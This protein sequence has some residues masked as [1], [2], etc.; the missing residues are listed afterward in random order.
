M[1]EIFLNC[2]QTAIPFLDDFL[3]VIM[4][5]CEASINIQS[6]DFS[7]SE[8]LKE[9]IIES[10]KCVVHGLSEYPESQPILQPYTTNIYKFIQLTC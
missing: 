10:I 8:S 2:G 7:Y 4:M 5:C 3:K 6:S 9:V 1:G